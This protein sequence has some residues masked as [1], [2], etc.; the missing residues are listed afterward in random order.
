MNSI[1]VKDDITGSGERLIGYLTNGIQVLILK[2]EG[3]YF[4]SNQILQTDK[5]LLGTYKIRWSIEDVFR[6]FK[7]QLHLEE[8]Q[9]RSHTAQER[10]LVSCMLAYIFLQK[11]QLSHENQTLYAIKESW[12]I[13]KRLGNNR[14]N[15]YAVKVLSA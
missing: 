7:D 12:M 10:H 8:C 6:F 9:A 5:H 11:E 1:Q 4:A 13:N 14:I 2:Y 3:K 15:H